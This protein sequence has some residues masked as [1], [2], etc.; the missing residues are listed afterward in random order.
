[1]QPAIEKVNR[2]LRDA[3]AQLTGLQPVERTTR[4]EIDELKRCLR[5][6]KF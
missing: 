4:D 1:M 6:I 3:S 5:G 2:E